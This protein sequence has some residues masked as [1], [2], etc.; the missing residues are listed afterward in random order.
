MAIFSYE[1]RFSRIM[2]HVAYGCYLNLLWVVCSL[3]LFTMGAS[4][5]ALY[6]VACKI[7]KNEEGDLT[8]QFFRAF[9]ENFRQATQLW[10]PL[11]ALGVVLGGDLFLLARLRAA[12]TGVP[13]VLWTLLLAVAIAGCIAY[14]VELMYVFPLLA[15]VD[16]TNRA[17]L[18]NSLLIGTHYLNCTIVVAAIHFAMFVV[19]VRFFTPILLLGEGFCAI[20]S[21]YLLNPVIDACATRPDDADGTSAEKAEP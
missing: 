3:P 12:T 18:K 7:A 6:Y 14:V 19:A 9:R 1:S 16:N 10:L 21:A 15:K 8:Q 2:S 11:L 4:T 13:A 5:C 17:M 20:M